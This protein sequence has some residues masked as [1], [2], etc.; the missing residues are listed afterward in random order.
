MLKDILFQ[1][2]SHPCFNAFSKFGILSKV[3]IGCFNSTVLPFFLAI[4]FLITK[5][6]SQND[7]F[8]KKIPFSKRTISVILSKQLLL[9]SNNSRLN[10]VFLHYRKKKTLH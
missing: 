10:Y 6:M 7:D 2:T 5:F 3:L 8:D 9:F 1:R 4:Q